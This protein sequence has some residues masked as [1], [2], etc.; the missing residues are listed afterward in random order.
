LTTCREF[1][2]KEE[3]LFVQ[4][5]LDKLLSANRSYIVQSAGFI[6]RASRDF[7]CYAAAVAAERLA[8]PRVS[9]A[10]VG[11]THSSGATS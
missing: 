2:T 5:Q 10:H 3:V 1:K 8:Q 4:Q 6:S 7:Q 11:R 9:A